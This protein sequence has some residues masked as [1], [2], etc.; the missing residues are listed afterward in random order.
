MRLKQAYIALIALA[1]LLSS[2]VFA[3]SKIDKTTSLQARSIQ[4][5]STLHLECRVD[6]SSFYTSKI[7]LIKTSDRRF[8]Y[9]LS[10]GHGM[11]IEG[12]NFSK[13]CLVIDYNGRQFNLLALYLPRAFSPGS[14]T[15][16]ALIRLPRIRDDN[17]VRF[18]LPEYEHMTEEAFRANAQAINFPKARGIG[19]NSQ[20]CQSYPSRVMGLMERNILVHNCRA[21]SGQ[22]GSPI[23]VST[24]QVDLLIGLHLGTGFVMRSE[25]SDKAGY[26][27]YFRFIDNAM[28]EEIDIIISRH[29]N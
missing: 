5:P 27:G 15:D 12:L 26:L 11:K 22:S 19:R 18:Q 2:N 24:N 6:E 16:W 17:I 1:F 20:L 28:V 14:E 8:D 7:A 3:A 9:G 13:D 4:E 10:T 23:S 25:I 21:V 29:F